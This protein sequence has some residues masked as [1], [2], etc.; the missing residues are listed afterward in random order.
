VLC[1][2]CN[3]ISGC[4]LLHQIP[5]SPPYF[6]A[7]V[8]RR[9][10]QLGSLP[11][12]NSAYLLPET[13]ETTEDLGWIRS[14]IEHEGGEAWLFRVE[15]LGRPSAD[16]LREAFSNLRCPDYKQLLDFACQLLRSI[17][18]SG[19][20]P[21]E[22]EPAWRRLKRKFDEVCRI[23]FFETPGREELEATMERIA[24]TLRGAAS[25]PA[26]K[27]ELKSLTG[28]N[29]GHPAWRESGSD[30]FRMADPEISR[31]FRSIPL[32]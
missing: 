11:I 5:P 9:L 17:Q 20:E 32:C 18:Q 30:R 15:P 29:L 24:S 23:D 31:S 4:L 13:D 26:V 2:S 25:Q 19:S 22:Y 1:H 16:A 27:P 28:R 14:E 7:R 12:K 10:N 6:R 21:E 3:R 8:L